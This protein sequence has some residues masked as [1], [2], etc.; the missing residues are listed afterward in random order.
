MLLKQGLNRVDKQIYACT[1]I[2]ASAKIKKNRFG[3]E[4]KN[5]AE[6]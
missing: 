4:M 6:Q 5:V 2:P 3:K 1:S